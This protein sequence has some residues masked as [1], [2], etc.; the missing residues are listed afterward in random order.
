VGEV[1]EAALPQDIGVDTPFSADTNLPSDLGL[2]ASDTAETGQLDASSMDGSDGPK[3][4]GTTGDVGADSATAPMIISIDFVGGRPNGT[5]GASGTVVM[6]ASESAGVKRA[7]NWNSAP[8]STGT[9][10]SLVSASGSPTTASASWNVAA[11][12]GVTD[13]WSV[14]F[15][16]AAGDTRMMNGYL[17]PRAAAYHATISVTGLPNPVSSGYDVYVYCYSYIG[18]VD[19]F[20]YQYNIGTTTYSVTQTGPSASTFPGYSLASGSDAGTPGA[21]NYVVFHNLS[22]P[23]FTLTALPRPSTN[24]TERAPVN[25][26]QIVYPSGS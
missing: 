21:G 4:G 26:I 22:G 20:S 13:T 2:I 8:G 7:T 16:D 10:S 25:G 12:D 14:S 3:T 24:G 11:V 6:S 9:L 5:A 15:T 17:D 19:T 1:V 18:L 23:S